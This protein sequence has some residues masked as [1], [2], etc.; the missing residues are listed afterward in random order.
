MWLLWSCANISE[1][2]SRVK[3]ANL[4]ACFRKQAP[5]IANEQALLTQLSLRNFVKFYILKSLFLR[6]F[7]VLSSLKQRN[8][9][10]ASHGTHI[11]TETR[12]IRTHTC[13]QARIQSTFSPTLPTHSAALPHELASL[14]R[15]RKKWVMNDNGVG[16]HRVFIS[17][18]REKERRNSYIDDRTTNDSV[19]F[20]FAANFF[21][22]SFCLPLQML[23]KMIV[24]F[25]FL[26]YSEGKYWV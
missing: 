1:R 15:R 25:F 6:I 3:H 24:W 26:C 4:G 5:L 14:R 7:R 13:I 10:L 22:L 8:R 23:S 12:S 11:R 18:N 2:Y 21:F 17:R 16:I 9:C 19:G 20:A